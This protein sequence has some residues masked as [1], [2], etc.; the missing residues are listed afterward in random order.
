M[1]KKVNKKLP[2]LTFVIPA[3][4]EEENLE[5]VLKNTILEA[6]KYLSDFEIVVINDGSSD[7]TGEIADLFAKK[8]K[9]IRVI[10]QKNGGYGA[11]MQRGLLETK[12]DFVVYM[13]ADGQFLIRDMVHCLP[14]ME[15]A[16][17]ILGY[18]GKRKDYSIY[19]LILSYGYIFILKV[20]FGISYHDVNWLNIW[21]TKEVKKIS[22]HSKG[23]FLLAE[24]IIK[25]KRKG[26]TILEAQSFYRQRRGGKAKNAKFSVVVH[27]LIDLLHFRIGSKFN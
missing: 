2:S 15:K 27:T 24:I 3:Y 17:I 19:R 14:L 1:P 21:R 18:R 20:L 5:W 13:P 23:V 12:K 11:A 25:F 26:L 6:P 9:K 22:I 16:D 8:N 10:H 7:K 4:N